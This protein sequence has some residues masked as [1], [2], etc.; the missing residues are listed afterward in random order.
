MSF[1][2][3]PCINESVAHFTCIIIT[4]FNLTSLFQ[5][6]LVVEPPVKCSTL[7]FVNRDSIGFC[8]CRICFDVQL[9]PVQCQNGHGY[10]RSCIENWIQGCE[11][12]HES[13]KCPTCAVELNKDNLVPNRTVEGMISGSLV[14]CFTQLPRLLLLGGAGAV[15]EQDHENMEPDSSSSSSSSSSSRKRK[16]ANSKAAKSVKARIDRC[17]WQGALRNAADHFRECEFAGVNCGFEG[18]GMVVVR[19]ELAAHSRVCD[20]RT[21]VCKWIG[22]SVQL[23]AM[24]RDQHHLDCPKR[25]V[26]CPNDYDGCHQSIAFDSMAQHRALCPYES[27][28]CPFAD[29]GCTARM[30]R[31]EIEKHKHDQCV[32]HNDL[33]LTAFKEQRQAMES[34]KDHVMPNVEKIVLRVK[35][36]VLIG[37]EPIVTRFPTNP[38]TICSEDLVTRGFT[39]TFSVETKETRPE[40]QDFMACILR[41][42]RVYSRAI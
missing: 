20:H 10:C 19:P 36:D 6:E 2:V 25:V 9:D 3:F 31:R 28:D 13:A 38:T 14:Y 4:D 11:T 37:K 30:L 22:C 16:S 7:L 41:S 21:F 17:I 12:R 5:M 29:V 35:H 33:M 39:M 34:M 23:K 26:R 27:C 1:P 8:E 15:G 32:K 40:Y 24:D 18:C 42:A